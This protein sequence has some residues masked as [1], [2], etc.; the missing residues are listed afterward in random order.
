MCYG[1]DEQFDGN[2]TE[3]CKVGDLVPGQS[4]RTP[5]AHTLAVLD[6]PCD[7]P[8]HSLTTNE[9]GVIVKV[10]DTTRLG[11]D[12]AGRLY[13]S[14]SLNP[15]KYNTAQAKYGEITFT[16]ADVVN[17]DDYIPQGES[18]PH[19]IRPWLLHDHGFVVA[20]VF[21][22]RLQDALDKAADS[23]KLDRYLISNEDLDDYG[24]NGDGITYLGNA[25]EPFDIES[26]EAIGLPNPPFSFVTLFNAVSKQPQ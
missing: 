23:D 12:R 1:R 6:L 17:V 14:R 21:A 24:S 16:D 13:A 11:R 15:L 3:V 5:D 20:V 10:S 9:S 26:L 22:T 4:F 18:N 19:N 7:E 2:K 25:S 8:G